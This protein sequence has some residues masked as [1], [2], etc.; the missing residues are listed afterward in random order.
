[1][2]KDTVAHLKR[3]RMYG[4]SNIVEGVL[5]GLIAGCVVAMYRIALNYADT[6]RNQIIQF[7]DGNWLLMLCWMIGL[8]ILGILVYVFVRFEPLISGS[9]IPQLEGEIVGALEQSWWKVVFA[10]F[11]GGLMSLFGGLALGREGP[12]IQLG[13]MMGKATGSVI[14]S[15]KSRQRFLLTCGASAGLSAAFHAPLAGVLFSMEEVHKNFSISL[16][17]GVM[18]SSLSADMLASWMVGEAVVFQIPIVENIPHS[19]YGYIVLLGIVLGACGAFYNWF[20]LQIQSLYQKMTGIPEVVKMCFPFVVAG[21]LAFS[22]PELL[23]SGHNLVEMLTSKDMFLSSMIFI[24]IGRFLFSAISFG[25]G[26][27]GGIF[28]P[29]LVLGGYI[30]GIFTDIASTYMHLD[31]VYINNF[32]VLAMAGYFAAIVRA[33]LTGI[34]LLFEMTGS[35]NQMLSLSVVSITAYVIATL[36]G[37]EPIYESL[38]ERLLHKQGNVADQPTYKPGEKVIVSYAVEATSYADGMCIKDVDLPEHC[39]IVSIQRG[40]NEIIPN[41]DTQILLGDLLLVMT[42]KELQQQTD[43]RLRKLTQERK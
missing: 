1:M 39:L 38:L 21:L 11:A 10:K 43:K 7:I 6:L 37:S 33:P 31:I 4:L 40:I 2:E 8:L 36:L 16:L 18:V 24:F 34:I 27:P 25:S 13:A 17:V 29:L 3:N 12:S 22:K 20:T 9:G 5:V 32:V 28:F 41:G 26:A 35:L 14:N 30:G 15:S 19:S 23:G 42:S